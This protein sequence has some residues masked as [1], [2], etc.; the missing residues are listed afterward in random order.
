M[1]FH[2]VI[3]EIPGGFEREVARALTAV[4]GSFSS[5]LALVFPQMSSSG[6]RIVTLSAVE[7]LFSGVSAFVHF[8]ITCCSA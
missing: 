4:V 6:A 1:F 3:T 7:R 2:H 8:Q 5:V